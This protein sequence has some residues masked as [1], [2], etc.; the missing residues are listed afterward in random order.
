MPTSTY[1]LQEM[2]WANPKVTIKIENNTSQS[3]HESC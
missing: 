1:M 2:P 3:E